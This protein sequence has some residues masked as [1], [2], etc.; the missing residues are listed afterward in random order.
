MQSVSFLIVA[1]NGL[2]YKSFIIT[3]TTVSHWA[4]LLARLIQ[5]KYLHHIPLTLWTWSWTFTV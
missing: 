1:D 5:S 3:F 4:L 2:T